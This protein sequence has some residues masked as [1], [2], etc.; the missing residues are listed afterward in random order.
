MTS[1]KK[2]RNGL[3]ES[4]LRDGI[5][6]WTNYYGEVIQIECACCHRIK[7]A[8]EFHANNFKKFNKQEH[9]ISCNNKILDGKISKVT[10]YIRNKEVNVDKLNDRQMKVLGKYLIEEIAHE[11]IIQEIEDL[12]KVKAWLE[13]IAE[14]KVI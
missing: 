9:C 4:I 7:P 13:F 8:K 10:K 1:N 6:Y 12:E 2:N 3:Y 11:K 5:R 14:K